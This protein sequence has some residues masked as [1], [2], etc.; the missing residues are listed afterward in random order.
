VNLSASWADRLIDLHLQVIRLQVEKLRAL[1]AT[2]TEFRKCWAS[3]GAHCGEG[4]S[5][6]PES[7]RRGRRQPGITVGSG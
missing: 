6:S 5:L 4:R 7:R 3:T 2:E 1:G